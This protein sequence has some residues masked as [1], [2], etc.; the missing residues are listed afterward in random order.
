MSTPQMLQKQLFIDNYL[1]RAWYTVKKEVVDQVLKITPFYSM[2]LE[3][4]RLRTK[5]P[6]G[7]HWEYTIRYAH[8]DANLKWFGKGDVFGLNSKEGLTR[9]KFEAR[10]LGN[11]IVRYWE[12]EQ[13]IRGE[14]KLIE[15]ATDIETSAKE[16]L[17]DGL[18]KALWLNPTANAKQINSLTELIS[19]TPAVGS[20][21]GLARAQNVHLWNNVIDFTGKTISANLL[22]VM[23]YVYNTCSLFRTG[24][25]R[26]PDMIIT[27]QRI[28][29]EY[30]GLCEELRQIES[31]TSDRASL[32]FGELRFKNCEMFWDP[33]CPTGHMYFLNSSTLEIP[34]DPEVYF[35][36]TEWKVIAGNTLDRTAQI[37]AR[38]QM[39]CTMP[40]KNA[41]IHNIPEP[42]I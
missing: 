21:G 17:H 41:V 20:F 36:M 30:E 26:A 38:L 6:D 12:E 25:Q 1:S 4:G 23:R 32:G 18:A 3:K 9:L 14:A 15:Y 42:A 28:Y 39:C 8:E 35:D 22:E 40:A 31:N 27:T 11:S 19:T 37:L 29:E 34:V 33:D 16:S 13:A 7:S 10:N 2:M 24:T 5:L